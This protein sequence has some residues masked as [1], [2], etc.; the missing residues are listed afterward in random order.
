[1]ALIC[2]KAGADISDLTNDDIV[3]TDMK[4]ILRTGKNDFYRSNFRY[5]YNSRYWLNKVN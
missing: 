4:R 3:R 5:G 2:L 1:M